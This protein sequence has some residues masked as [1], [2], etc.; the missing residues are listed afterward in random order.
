[1]QNSHNVALKSV[2]TYNKLLSE[3]NK[4]LGEIQADLHQIAESADSA[5]NNTALKTKCESYLT[6]INNKSEIKVA[7]FKESFQKKPARDMDSDQPG[8][9][10]RTHLNKP[11]LNSTTDRNTAITDL[12]QMVSDVMPNKYTSLIL[13]TPPFP[14]LATRLPPAQGTGRGQGRG[15][16]RKG[17]RGRGWGHPFQLEKLIRTQNYRRKHSHKHNP[18]SNIVNLSSYVLSYAETNILSK[19]LSFI[20]KPKHID[21]HDIQAGLLKFRSQIVAQF[22][23]CSKELRCEQT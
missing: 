10:K 8:P 15:R 1:M 18:G 14:H 4:K 23:I 2:T 21:Q 19:D 9:S 13:I 17:W 22:E 3:A 16:G 11:D 20:P 6:N 5:E 7:E 12:L